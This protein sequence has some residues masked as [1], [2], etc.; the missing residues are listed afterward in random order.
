M[1]LLKDMVVFPFLCYLVELF[2]TD[3]SIHLSHGAQSGEGGWWL[4]RTKGEKGASA[5]V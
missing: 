5:L 1:V 4:G 2:P 3:F